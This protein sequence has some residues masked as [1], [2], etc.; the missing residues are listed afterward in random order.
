LTSVSSSFHRSLSDLHSMS[1][2]TAN[3]MSMNALAG[4]IT[5]FPQRTVRARQMRRSLVVRA[6]GDKL[7]ETVQGAPGVSVPDNGEKDSYE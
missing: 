4:S 5:P 3:V 1:F 7:R 2:A 6:E